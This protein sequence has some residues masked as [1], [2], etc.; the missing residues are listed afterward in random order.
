MEAT[1]HAPFERHARTRWESAPHPR[2]AQV[3]ALLD[4]WEAHEGRPRA[5]DEATA[6]LAPARPGLTPDSLRALRE[7]LL[8]DAR[9]DAEVALGSPLTRRL[10]N[11]AAS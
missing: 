6:G 3:D 2:L 5:A 4:A 7:A 9:A 8:A 10:R 1:R 11:Y